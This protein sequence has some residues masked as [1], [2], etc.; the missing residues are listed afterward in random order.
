M[1]RSRSIFWPYFGVFTLAALLP[2]AA[3]AVLG[4]RSARG[5]ILGDRLE[6][7]QKLSELK[8]DEIEAGIRERA[9]A[10]GI[11]AE[12]P[13]LR[14]AVLQALGAASSESEARL[15]GI[16]EG[17]GRK[18][19]NFESA[20]VFDTSGRPLGTVGPGTSED[21]WNGEVLALAQES[22]AEG[23]ALPGPIH[24]GKPATSRLRVVAAVT[25][26][27]GN[28][29]AALVSLFHLSGAVSSILGESEGGPEIRTYL[30][31]TD[32]APLSAIPGG[33]AGIQAILAEPPTK[34]RHE[35]C[36]NCSR[37]KCHYGEYVAPDGVRVIGAC[38]PSQDRKWMVVS[39]SPV[40]EALASLHSFLAVFLVTSACG[41]GA[42]LLAGGL[43]ARRISHPIRSVAEAARSIA[44]G[45]L[46]S[47]A[48][49][50]KR[51]EVGALVTAFNSL[52]DGLI[53]SRE[54][55]QARNRELE[56]ALDQLSRV[57]DRLVQIEA[58]SAVGR[59]A[60]SLVHEIRNPLSSVKMN[61]Q[62]LSKPLSGDERYAEHSRIAL[63]QLERLERMLTDL[64][65]FGRPLELRLEN[66]KLE[67]CMARAVGDVRARA[68]ARDIDL[69]TASAASIELRA[70]PFRIAQ[71]LVNLLTNAI[72]A[73][74]AGGRIELKGSE[75]LEGGS[76]WVYCEVRDRG[77]GIRPEHR[78]E[79]FDPFF[80]T[81]EGGTG[82]GLAMVKKIAAL[83][84]GRVEMESELGSGTV[85]RLALPG[86]EPVRE[87]PRN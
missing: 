25:G 71:A 74:P 5:A 53:T 56:N 68:Q 22:R 58:I 80:T 63:D 57:R 84:G 55:V 26:K 29:V 33:A 35:G 79:I 30:L 78:E 24:A 23:I 20:G 49:Y 18:W 72:D 7:M 44:G 45:D 86:E 77:T 70:D 75:K 12:L 31:G 13:D 66:V 42:M 59:V 37:G 76:R 61:L 2:I 36:E 6:L 48:T 67:D 60:A 46:S 15:E 69:A 81:K 39:E 47:R 51:D 32:G 19:V 87:D 54:E 40:K 10:V 82:L 73:S 14:E 4:Y 17:P 50:E 34:F 64:L 8:R 27:S 11:L 41:L 21:L 83:H 9:R 28:L 43:L 85:M 38:Y 52:V 65:D 16:L 1:N 3:M 62:I